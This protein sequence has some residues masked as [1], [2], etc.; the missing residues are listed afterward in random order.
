MDLLILLFA[1]LVGELF[2]GVQVLR[3]TREILHLFLICQGTAPITI[4][5][6][7]I[8]STGDYTCGAV[9]VVAG[10]AFDRRSDPMQ[11][12][13]RSRGTIA[14]IGGGQHLFAFAALWLILT[15]LCI[16]PFFER[17][18][19]LVRETYTCVTIPPPCSKKIEVISS[20]P[21]CT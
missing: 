10:I 5:F 8:S 13:P 19:D 14:S 1:L 18:I 11:L 20:R 15:L 2:G 17:R 9:G 16:F 6:G 3:Q 4:I 12:W 7:R 21:G